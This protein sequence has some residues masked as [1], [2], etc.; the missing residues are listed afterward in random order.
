M[1]QLMATL[2]GYLTDGSDIEK[3]RLDALACAGIRLSDLQDDG[4]W[5]RWVADLHVRA[6]VQLPHLLTEANARWDAEDPR[7]AQQ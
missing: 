2:E 7:T 3:T 5:V 4:F 6:G 1:R